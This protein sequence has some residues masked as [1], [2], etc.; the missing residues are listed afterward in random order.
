M[1]TASA[2]ATGSLSA[3]G[4]EP[5]YAFGRERRMHARAYDYWVSLLH[6]HA[7]P[8][9]A[10]V[11]P[12]RLNDFSDRSVMVDV[13]ASGGTPTIAHVGRELRDEAGITPV[14]PTLEDVPPGTLLSELLSRFSDIIAYRAPV[15]FEA[16]F[17]G[18]DG[19]HVL[20]RGILLPF[21]DDNG[22]L[23]SVYG[24]IS[25]KQLAR[26]EP[27]PD[28]V[29]AVNSVMKSRPMLVASSAWGDGPGA[30]GFVSAPL[31]PQ[32]LDQRL[33][34]ARTWAAL[35]ATDRVRSEAS[36]NAALGAAYDYLVAARS[37]AT[38][39]AHKAV[40][41][42]FGNDLGRLDRIRYAATLDHADRLGLGPGRL[43]P[44]LDNHGGG[45]ISAAIAE[46]KARRAAK[47]A[48]EAGDHLAWA[49]AQESLGHIELS[50][51]D[52]DFLLIGRRATRG[53]D[54]IAPVPADDLFTGAALARARA[55]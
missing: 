29:A 5:I 34:A 35:A 21:A 32:P 53:V 51:V 38:L 30:A 31:P 2:I 22:T 8:R 27:A 20:H 39:T 50:P 28:I 49:D 45:H 55:G 52:D 40:R 12:D 48:A 19:G 4:Q 24:V 54:V 33:A 15:G 47:H 42:V 3:P 43:T 13:A 16:E 18:R 26:S 46:R 37:T 6:G 25:W 41:L 11:D 44:W 1:A 10:D 9:L 36:L 14:R 7:M 17:A 23:A